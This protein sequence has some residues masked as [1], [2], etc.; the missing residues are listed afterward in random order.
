MPVQY[1]RQLPPG[2][3]KRCTVSGEGDRRYAL[4]TVEVSDAASPSTA[5]P[6]YPIGI[7]FGLNHIAALSASVTV[8]APKFFRRS[9]RSLRRAQRKLSTR[10]L[11]NKLTTGWARPHDL[12]AFEDMVVGPFGRGRMTKSIHDAGWA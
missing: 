4:I 9:E 6:K 11:V 3:V 1:D 10:D 5:E 8:E 12:I 7:D 2:R